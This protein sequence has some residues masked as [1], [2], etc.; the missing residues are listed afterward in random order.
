[1]LGLFVASKVLG[2]G[3]GQGQGS[4]GKGQQWG[5]GRCVCIQCRHFSRFTSLL[6]QLTFTAVCCIH[7]GILYLN[8]SLLAATNM[9]ATSAVEACLQRSCPVKCRD[10]GC[11]HVGQESTSCLQRHTS[12]LTVSTICGSWACKALLSGPRCAT[13]VR[14]TGM[15]GNK[16]SQTK[17]LLTQMVVGT[18]G[19]AGRET[20]GVLPGSCPLG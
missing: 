1:M 3:S 2:V 19:Q 7:A 10:Q 13:P 9:S 15:D 12:L 5:S 14:V 20:E 6:D 4:S 17:V 18:R 11:R 8:R 16:A